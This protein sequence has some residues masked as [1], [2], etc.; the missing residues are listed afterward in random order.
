M[1]ETLTVMSRQMCLMNLSS[2][3]SG[4]TRGSP[5]KLMRAFK[6]SWAVIFWNNKMESISSMY[7]CWLVYLSCSLP[8]TA[9]DTYRI[10]STQCFEIGDDGLALAQDKRLVLGASMSKPCDMMKS[11]GSDLQRVQQ[12]V[13]IQALSRAVIVSVNRTSN[14]GS[15]K[16]SISWK[17]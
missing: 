2:S 17:S 11:Y 12:V 1:Y 14:L 3:R 4:W 13:S 6:A 16:K 8:C 7:V 15:C 9:K 5:D 10:F